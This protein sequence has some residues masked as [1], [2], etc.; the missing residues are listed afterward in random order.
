MRSENVR[1]IFGV[2]QGSLL[3]PLLFLLYRVRPMILENTLVGMQMTLLCYPKYLSSV[4]KC[5]LYRLYA[6]LLELVT[7]ANV[8]NAGKSN[9]TKAL[10]ISMSR[11]LATHFSN[12]LSNV[13]KLERLTE[14]KVLRVVLNT[15]LSLENHI[16]LIA[17][18]ASSKLGIMRKAL[19]LFG[20]P[21]L[22]SS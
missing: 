13:T 15:K 12:L 6:I 19:C 3:G 22:L 14:L 8:G 2:P 11:K 20:D 5:M 16:R 1:V 21:F 7:G 18:S 9:E 17:A 10:V 4:A